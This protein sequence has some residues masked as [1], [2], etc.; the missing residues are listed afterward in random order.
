[1]NTC[2]LV[3]ISSTIWVQSV[4]TTTSIICI[5]APPTRLIPHFAALVVP[6][7][8]AKLRNKP[9]LNGEILAVITPYHSF[10]ISGEPVCAA[11]YIWWQVDYYDSSQNGRS[12]SGWVAENDL[13]TYVL[14]PQPSVSTDFS[15]LDTQVS[16]HV[17]YGG[18]DFE[19][20]GI[21]GKSIR[22]I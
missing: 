7:Q 10:P 11:S 21:L 19:C 12:Y 3:R 15:M 2:G 4:A 14:Q 18:A 16:I 5:G 22:A 8:T 1:L 20:T 17:Q 13:Q 9:D 6:G